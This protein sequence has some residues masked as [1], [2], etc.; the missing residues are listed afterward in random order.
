MG[1]ENRFENTHSDGIRIDGYI[2]FSRPKRTGSFQQWCRLGNKY[3]SIY[4]ITPYCETYKNTTPVPKNTIGASRTVTIQANKTAGRRYSRYARYSKRKYGNSCTTK[5][6]I[7]MGWM[8]KAG[9]GSRSWMKKKIGGALPW[10][11]KAVNIIDTGHWGKQ[12]GGGV[13]LSHDVPNKI[14]S[15]AQQAREVRNTLEDMVDVR[16]RDVRRTVKK[17]AGNASYKDAKQ[18]AREKRKEIEQ[19]IANTRRQLNRAKNALGKR[20]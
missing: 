10:A 1:L 9:N 2:I 18:L 11:K 3:T 19:A 8:K 16:T 12:V 13:D 14:E 6:T 20:L 4:E 5:P 7:I 17:P 15:G